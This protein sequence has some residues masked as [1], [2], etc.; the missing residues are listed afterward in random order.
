MENLL[1][2]VHDDYFVPAASELKC[3]SSSDPRKTLSKIYAHFASD[4]LYRNSIYLMASTGIM[5]FF[6]FFFWIINARLYK[7]EQVGCLL[8]TSDAADE[9]DRVC[10]R[11]CR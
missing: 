10:F 4:S 8:Y 2:I 1:H 11:R 7:P 5:A 3:V 6:G 9:E